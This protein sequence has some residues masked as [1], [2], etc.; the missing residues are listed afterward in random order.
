ME[1]DG[2]ALPSLAKGL[3][4]YFEIVK[5]DSATPLALFPEGG[6]AIAFARHGNFNSIF[7][8]APSLSPEFIARLS[9]A[10]GVWRYAPEGNIVISDGRL[11]GVCAPKGGRIPLSLP[12]GAF[13]RSLDGAVSF[14]GGEAAKLDFKPGETKIFVIGRGAK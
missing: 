7:C 5:T 3:A 11:L 4:D 10:A 6:T 13:A 14:E 9:E 2:K 12:N 1:L 8:A